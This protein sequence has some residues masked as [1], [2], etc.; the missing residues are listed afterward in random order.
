MILL[1]RIYTDDIYGRT[2]AGNPSR[3]WLFLSGCAALMKA[4]WVHPMFQN[5]LSWAKK[6]IRNNSE[7]IEHLAKQSWIKFQK[8]NLSLS[9]QVK[10]SQFT[11]KSSLQP[12]FFGSWRTFFNDG[13]KFSGFHAGSFSSVCWRP[14]WVASWDI[15]SGRIT[16]SST[17]RFLCW[18][19]VENGLLASILAPIFHWVG[20]GWGWNLSLGGVF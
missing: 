1:A 16:G 9:L 2:G 11:P 19:R 12:Y 4:G 13:P 15:I 8:F 17:Q 10:T 20:L 5:Q 18:R 14:P 7:R 6:C 3:V